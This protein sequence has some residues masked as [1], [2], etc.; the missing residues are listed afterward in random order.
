M[1]DRLCARTPVAGELLAAAG[2]EEE[3]CRRI[4]GAIVSG[5]EVDWRAS[6]RAPITVG[7]VTVH[8]LEPEASVVGPGYSKVV[9]AHPI[10]PAE[11]DEARGWTY[12]CVC[13][14]PLA[15]GEVGRDTSAGV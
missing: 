9:D 8:R 4:V 14:Q 15:P 3:F 7:P 13:Y 12:V 6:Y 2:G 1:R 5:V 10:H 11:G